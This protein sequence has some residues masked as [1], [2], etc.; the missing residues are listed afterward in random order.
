MPLKT[1]L[2]G[3]G[4]G[5]TALL[6]VLDG[7]PDIDL[8]GVVDKSF[9]APGL[10]VAR[11]MGLPIAHNIRVLLSE[12]PVD[13]VIDA[14]GD[15]D[16]PRQVRDVAGKTVSVMSG[17]AS[18]FLWDLL[19]TSERLARSEERY[20]QLLEDVSDPLFLNRNQRI[21]YVNPAF[22]KTFG[23]PLEEIVGRHYTCIFAPNCLEQV[24]NYHQHRIAGQ[25][26]PEHYEADVVH[27]DGSILNCLVH[28]RVTTAGGVQ[29]VVVLLT[30]LTERKRLEREREEFFRFMV[31][32]LR[33]PLSPIVMGLSLLLR[34]DS[35]LEQKARRKLMQ[36]SYRGIARLQEFVDGFLDLSRLQRQ[37]VTVD[38]EDFP[39]RPVVQGVVEEQTL[40]ALDKE[41]SIVNE[42]PEDLTVRCDRRIIRTVVQNYVNNAI[43]YTDAGTISIRTEAADPGWIRFCVRDTGSGFEPDERD[44]L[45]GEFGRLKRHEGVKGTG[46]G[47]AL[48]KLL[49]SAYGGQVAAESEGKGK[50]STFSATLPLSVKD[51]KPAED[52]GA[53]PSSESSDERRDPAPSGSAPREA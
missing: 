15:P 16:L 44:R 33:A 11:A 47:L 23:Y 43:K 8:V 18:K 1:L 9:R 2:V 13:L 37:T 51:E 36:V 28:A 20:R 10:E 19:G 31:H 48:V 45:F 39:L 42:I 38:W 3:A 29:T 6:Y 35:Q 41:L 53:G 40:L 26:A 25:P 34:Q 50:G 52:G 4:Q 32:E 27:K 21:D 49:V 22:T 14:T 12:G 24:A 30:D 5:G 46:L 7:D 17:G